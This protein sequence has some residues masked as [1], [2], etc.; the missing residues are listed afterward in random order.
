MNLLDRVILEWSHKTGKGY[1]DINSKEDMDLFEYMFGFNPTAEVKKEVNENAQTDEVEDIFSLIGGD[2]KLTKLGIFDKLAEHTYKYHKEDLSDITSLFPNS[3]NTINSWR[4]YIDKNLNLSNV[5]KEVENSVLNYAISKGVA[6]KDVGNKGRGVDLVIANT[7]VEIKSSKNNKIN[8]QL[9]TTYYDDKKL[10]CFITNTG[11]ED[12]QVRVVSGR[13]LRKLS[14][15]KEL[16]STGKLD[17]KKLEAQIT[18][19]LQS[20]DLAGMIQTALVQGPVDKKTSFFIG[21][22]LKVRFLIMLEP[23]YTRNTLKELEG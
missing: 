6:A 23:A 17:E 9:N 22:N 21:N 3:V 2:K 5:G 1:P 8:T 19:G 10:Y 7:Y 16:Y 14:F 18:K 20:L 13:L 15:G 12:I 11:G 4:N